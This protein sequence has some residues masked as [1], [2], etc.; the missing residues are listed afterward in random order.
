[1]KPAVFPV[2]TSAMPVLMAILKFKFD[3]GGEGVLVFLQEAVN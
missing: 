1:V 2:A 3:G